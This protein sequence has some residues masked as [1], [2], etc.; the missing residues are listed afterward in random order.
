MRNSSG[1]A[2]VLFIIIGIC[3]CKI[4][5]CYSEDNNHG[6]TSNTKHTPRQ[7]S[8]NSAIRLKGVQGEA[9]YQASRHL[10]ILSTKADYSHESENIARARARLHNRHSNTNGGLASE[11]ARRGYGKRSLTQS[12]AYIL[13]VKLTEDDISLQCRPSLPRHRQDRTEDNRSDSRSRKQQGRSRRLSRDLYSRLSSV[14]RSFG[15]N[16]QPPLLQQ[17]RLTKPIDQ[18]QGNASSPTSLRTQQSLR[19]HRIQRALARECRL[20]MECFSAHFRSRTNPQP[21]P[22]TGAHLLREVDVGTGRWRRSSSHR[23]P[24]NRQSRF[25]DMW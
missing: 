17:A 25:A 7:A 23:L 8:L 21:S 20:L 24:A 15:S 2:Q 19:T 4:T 5:K 12:T 16:R 3:V 11:S 6:D 22:K 14:V 18:W 9:R 10:D 1:A 13:Q